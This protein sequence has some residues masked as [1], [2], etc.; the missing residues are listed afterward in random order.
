[1]AREVALLRVQFN[2]VS[3]L[4]RYRPLGNEWARSLLCADAERDSKKEYMEG[5][6][7][8][9]VSMAHG[10]THLPRE[11]GYLICLSCSPCSAAAP[12][13]VGANL[14]LLVAMRCLTVASSRN[15]V[16]SNGCGEIHQG[17]P[18][19]SGCTHVS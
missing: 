13:M 17:Y 6:M 1:M 15:S 3:H 2:I 4:C 19:P 7:R 9:P 14:A 10:V 18:A 12:G 16:E 5:P 8:P 11:A